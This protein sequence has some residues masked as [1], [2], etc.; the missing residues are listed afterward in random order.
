MKLE[1]IKKFMNDNP[2][3]VDVRDIFEKAE[4]DAEEFYYMR[5]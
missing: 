3:L 4:A 1:N 2:V 5:L